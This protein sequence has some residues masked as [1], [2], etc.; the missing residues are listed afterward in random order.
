MSGSIAA[1]HASLRWDLADFDRGTAHIEG[2]FGRLRGFIVGVSEAIAAAGRRMTLGITAPLA[3]IAAYTVKAASDAQELQS[4]FDYTFGRMADRMNVWAEETG[5]AMGR[6]TQEMQEGALA[7]GVLFKQ[8]APTEEAAAR[9]S[10]QFAE[11]AQD[12]SSFYNVSFDDALLRIRS[13]LTGEAEPLRKFGVFLSENA[14]KAKAL[15]LGLISAGQEIN[16][17]GKIMAR[18]A[19]IAESM[20]DATGDVERTS[21]SF[22]NRVRALRSDLQ[23]LATEIGE[24]FLPIAERVIGWLRSAVQWLS[25]LPEGVKEAMINMAL[26]AAA[27]G[28]VLMV[29]NQLAIFVLPLLL[30]NLGPVAAAVSFLLNPLGTLIVIGGKLAGEF[31][32]LGAVLSRLGPL[33]MRAFGPIGWAIGLAITFRE[34]IGNAFRI[35]GQLAEQYLGPKLDQLWAAFDRLGA[36]F[37]QLADGPLGQLILAFGDVLG[38][39]IERL[40]TLFG[41]GMVAIVGAVIDAVTAIVRLFGDLTQAWNDTFSAIDAILRGDWP[42]AWEH[43][44]NAAGNAIRSIAEWLSGLFPPLNLLLRLLGKLRG[45]E[46]QPS[47]VIRTG[48]SNFTHL[49]EML[50]TIAGLGDPEGNYAVA[51]EPK[52]SRGRGSRGRTGPSA[53][54]L[55]ERRAEIALEQQIAVARERGDLDALRA[56]ER[57]RDLRDRITQYQR[58]GL[59]LALAQTAAER[60]MSELDAAREDARMRELADMRFATER[61]VARLNNDQIHLR[62]LD[63]EEDLQRRIID[64][65]QTGFDLATAERIALEQV[66]AIEEARAGLV[67][68]RLAD[69]RAAHEIELARLRGE[70]TF[71]LEE[72]ARIRARIDD[73]EREG[74]MTRAEAEAAAMRE[75][76]ERSEAAM[77]GTFRDAFRGGLQAAMDGNLGRFF[78]NWLREHSFNALSRVLERLADQLAGLISGQGGSGGGLLGALGSIFGATNTGNGFGGGAAAWASAS[79]PPGFATGGSF[80]LR[81]FPG[82]DQNLLSLNGNP[83]ARVSDGEIVDIRQGAQ[84][85]SGGVVRVVLEDTTGLFRTAV[86]AEAGQIVA[87]TAPAIIEAGAEAGLA[88]VREINSASY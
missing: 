72:A 86:R 1:L 45:D 63:Q 7:L 64:L 74:G 4:A 5:N 8:A 77:I 26:F 21:D 82:I 29:L 15:E 59:S 18:A 2:V 65:Q 56:L 79:T 62:Y 75:A 16:E 12:A 10:Q 39:V 69:Q 57:Q 34:E 73:L 30:V 31:G 55:A 71:Q 78:E 27:V 19:I 32:L 23:E 48:G 85:G 70:D 28:P 6:A 47:A 49:R 66:R 44:K 25:A 37:R 84:G 53:Q 76:A 88:K 20:A 40:I 43:A 80:R 51:E 58:A 3:G 61:E 42:T 67:T 46:E 38:P 83:I 60:D 87:E 13:G 54:E 36:A 81:G 41:A 9:L 33:I 22:A 68:R 35:I 50:D 14:V 17:Q 24:R 52:A 11:L